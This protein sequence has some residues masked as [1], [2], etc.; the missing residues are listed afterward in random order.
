MIRFLFVAALL[1]A[2]LVAGEEHTVAAPDD[3]SRWHMA[4][5]SMTAAHH[6][7]PATVAKEAAPV[8]PPAPHRELSGSERAA[9][10]QALNNAARCTTGKLVYDAASGFYIP[11]F[12][13]GCLRRPVV[14]EV[15]GVASRA[16]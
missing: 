15:S 10:E 9:L 16:D 12:R 8:Q 7:W 1:A 4:L 13:R 3:G 2:P 6:Q 5:W 11:A 14:V